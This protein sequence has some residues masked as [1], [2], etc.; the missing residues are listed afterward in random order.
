MKTIVTKFIAK[1]PILV[2]VMSGGG[3]NARIV[4]DTK[5]KTGDVIVCETLQTLVTETLD[6]S[7]KVQFPGEK[8]SLEF[9]TLGRL[10]ASGAIEQIVE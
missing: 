9:E 8:I 5:A 4:F 10:V 6:T 1:T 7:V 3:W 2:P